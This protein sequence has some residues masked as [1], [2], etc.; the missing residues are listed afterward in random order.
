MT[1]RLALVL[2]VALLSL[3]LT[4]VQGT[5]N[6][7]GGCVPDQPLWSPHVPAGP[8]P[9]EC[10]VGEETDPMGQVLPDFNPLDAFAYSIEITRLLS[11]PPV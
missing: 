10:Q 4:S 2:C 3:P 11:G 9:I 8:I 5:E 6:P 1:R 7:P